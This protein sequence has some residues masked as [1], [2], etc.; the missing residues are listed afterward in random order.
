MKTAS[1]VQKVIIGNLLFIIISLVFVIVF[2]DIDIQNSFDTMLGFVG[3]LLGALI[4]ASLAGKFALDAANKTIENNYLISIKEFRVMFIKLK[5]TLNRLVVYYNADPF[6]DNKGLLENLSEIA[7]DAL[8]IIDLEKVPPELHPQIEVLSLSLEEI[9]ARHTLSVFGKQPI[10]DQKYFL[11]QKVSNLE[12]N[13][14]A[15]QVASKVISKKVN[16]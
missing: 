11:G 7:K 12:D 4:G 13:I 9:K 10:K 8:D 2:S 6:G 16:I 1:L 14:K 5:I 15:I 3:T